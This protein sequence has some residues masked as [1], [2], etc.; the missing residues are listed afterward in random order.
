MQINIKNDFLGRFSQLISLASGAS[1][2]ERSNNCI[3]P[4]SSIIIYSSTVSNFSDSS[5]SISYYY[6]A[7]LIS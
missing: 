6:D 4:N 2:Y 5:Y 3:S 1:S 7:S